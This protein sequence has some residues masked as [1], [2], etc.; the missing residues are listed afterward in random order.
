MDVILPVKNGTE[1]RLR[2][3]ARPDKAVQE[4]ISHLGLELPSAPKM[5]QNVVS[6]NNT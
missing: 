4:L 1:L 3:V 6:K 2:V 5:I